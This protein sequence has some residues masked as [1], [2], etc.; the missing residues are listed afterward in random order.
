[1]N[2]WLLSAAVVLLGATLAIPEVEARRLGGG[3]NVGAQR[4]VT[5]APKA[6]AQQQQ[7]AAPGQQNPAAAPAAPGSR[8]GTLLGG[9][10]I[11]GLIGYLFGGEGLL[12]FLM[13]ALL[14]VAGV[15]VLAAIL[16]R[17]A[18]EAPQPMQFAG[19]GGQ[20]LM[21]PPAGAAPSAAHTRV[22]ADFDAAGFLR[23]AKTN[24]LKLQLAND[25][26]ELDAIREFATDEVFAQLEADVRARA[27]AQQTDIVSLE[28]ELLELAEENGRFW[29]S[30]RFSG[31]ERETPASTPAAF[32][33]V[34]NLVKPADGSSGWLLA[35]IQQMH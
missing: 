13:L 2:K 21:P 31:M 18:A 35:G 29:A 28:A 24:F 10:A 16:R 6:P 30:V 8:W 25:R 5:P 22:P 32:E 19:M 4:N 15:A 7:Q 33:E 34:W 17:R 11:G 12:G 27:G 9:L 14:G 26:R 20:T 1:M 23:G 3:R